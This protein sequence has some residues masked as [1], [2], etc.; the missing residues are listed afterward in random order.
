MYCGMR[1]CSLGCQGNVGTIS[2]GSEGDSQANAAAGTTDEKR[3][4]FTHI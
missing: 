2:S 4:S 3:F 1:S